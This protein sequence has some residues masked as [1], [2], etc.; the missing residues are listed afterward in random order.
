MVYFTEPENFDPEFEVAGCFVE[1]GGKI[2]LLHRHPDKPQGGTWCLPAGKL[3]KGEETVQAIIRETK[4]ETGIDV[5]PG[6]LE[7]LSKYFVVYP[8][9]KFVYHIFKTRLDSEPNIVLSAN[10]HVD[11]RWATPAEALSMDL[12]P[13]EDKCIKLTYGL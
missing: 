12:I 5:E 7:Y 11:H 9:F 10:E 3:D 4:E 2:L 13:D 1:H 8:E 6:R